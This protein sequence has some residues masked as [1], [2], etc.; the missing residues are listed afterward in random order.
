[1]EGACDIIVELENG[2]SGEN[3]DMTTKQS[4]KT[5]QG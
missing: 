4:T 3:G 1:M 5:H 2:N